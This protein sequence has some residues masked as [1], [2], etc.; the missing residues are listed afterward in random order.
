[1]VA[2][3]MGENS[4]LTFLLAL[5]GPKTR[6]LFD[7]VGWTKGMNPESNTLVMILQV[8]AVDFMKLSN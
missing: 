3:S 1:M 6:S 8:K 5:R 4:I 2:S 7:M